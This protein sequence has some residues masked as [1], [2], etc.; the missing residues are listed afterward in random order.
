MGGGTTY[1]CLAETIRGNERMNR[2]FALPLIHSLFDAERCH[3]LALI[4]ARYRIAFPKPSTSD[5]QSKALRTHVP[6]WNLT[7]HSPIGLAAGFDKD[8][9]AIHQ[10]RSHSRFSLVEIG[11]VTPLPQDGNPRPRVFLLPQCQALINRY[12]FN[13][14]GHGALLSRMEAEWKRISAERK[15]NKDSSPV[16]IG[17]N[18]GKNKNSNDAS[19]DYSV[20]V[21]LIG[22][23]VDYIVINVSSPNTPGLR[24]LQKNK[25]ELRSI[26]RESL[27]AR[28]RI[29][30]RAANPPRLLLKISPDLSDCE[31]CDVVAVATETR[32]DG[33]VVGN[34]SLSRP[35]VQSAEAGGLSGK[36][37]RLLSTEIVAKVYRLTDGKVPIIG[38]GGVS[39]GEDAYEK[40]R[41]GASLVQLYT[42]LVYQGF[43]VVEKIRRDLADCLI[44]DGFNSVQEAVGADHV[45]K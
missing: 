45:R 5:Q 44:R 8:G 40:I 14:A 33:L 11:T 3:Q 20:G 18:L 4:A 30:T 38:C 1:F 28:S 36:P 6:A 16:W 9:F 2:D 24:A 31:L 32:V 39:S 27:N 43:P 42:A 15:E 37:L 34:T 21:A 7:L 23:Y 17:I 13:S 12:G 22:P 26:L 41:A 19:L 35:G 10:L 25:D 29:A